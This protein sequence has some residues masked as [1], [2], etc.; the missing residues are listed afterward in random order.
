LANRVLK[1]KAFIST[2]PVTA[3]TL[4][5]GS[6]NFE[7]RLPEIFAN[8]YAQSFARQVITGDGTGNNFLGIFPGANDKTINCGAVGVPRIN[9]FVGLALELRDHTDM[10]VIITSPSIYQGIMADPTTGV[11]EKYKEVL[12]RDRTIEGVPV[13]VT[14]FAPSNVV[15]G[16]TVAVAGDLYNYGM[17]ISGEIRISPILQVGTAITYF[18]AMVFANGAPSV[19]RNFIGLRTL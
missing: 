16:A 3:E 18:Q 13:L 2:L 14:G 9:D 5:L 10:G 19:P 6:V 12:I 11:A 17:A 4:T 1:P 15:S 7:R 8:A